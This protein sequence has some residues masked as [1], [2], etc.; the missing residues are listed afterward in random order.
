MLI[1]PLSIIILY[2]SSLVIGFCENKFRVKKSTHTVEKI[3]FFILL[4]F[5]I[6]PYLL[7]L[8]DAKIQKNNSSLFY[9]RKLVAD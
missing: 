7:G 2:A 5:G 1:M 3:Y 9:M 8:F 6:A 4:N